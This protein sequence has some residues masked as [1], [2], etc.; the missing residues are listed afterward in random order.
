M[1]PLTT[2]EVNDAET[3]LINQ[4]QSGI[5]SSDPSGFFKITVPNLVGYLKSLDIFQDDKG[6]LRVGGRL[7]KVS[8][9]YSQKHPAT[10]AKNY[11]LSKVYFITLHKKLFHV[12]PQGLLNARYCENTGREASWGYRFRIERS[13]IDHNG[14]IILRSRDGV[15]QGPLLYWKIPS[16]SENKINII[17]LT[18]SAKISLYFF[19]VILPFR[20]TI[21]PA[22]TH[23]MAVHMAMPTPPS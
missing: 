19:P 20:F 16:P 11:K 6:V 8:I 15:S 7:E 4:D 12:G 13:K 22:E 3:W 2:S 9:P 17:G 21:G 5:N 10:L 18:R 1:K 23:D 14:L